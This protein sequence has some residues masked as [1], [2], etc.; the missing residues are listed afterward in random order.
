MSN[1]GWFGLPINLLALPYPPLILTAH[2]DHLEH[3]AVLN[4]IP[5]YHIIDI[6][7]GSSLGES[8]Q[9]TGRQACNQG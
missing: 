2:A 3:A 8:A 5:R 4:D 6:N 1:D 7:K 9:E